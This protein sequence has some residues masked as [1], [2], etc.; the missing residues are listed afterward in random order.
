MSNVFWHVGVAYSFQR[1]STCG[2]ASTIRIGTSN[3]HGQTFQVRYD[4]SGFFGA[5]EGA[6]VFSQDD[7]YCVLPHYGKGN[8]LYSKIGVSKAPFWMWKWKKLH[9][10]MEHPNAIRT[11]SGAM[12]VVAGLP[13]ETG[14]MQSTLCEIDPVRL[15][16][17]RIETIP[18]GKSCFVGLAMHDDQVFL[19]YRTDTDNGSTVHLA[20]VLLED[21]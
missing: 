6:L 19:S 14:K 16:L 7:G 10:A 11:K 9:M 12:L 15:K 2:N 3:D 18:S 8:N 13:D 1:G 21:Q 5:G 20:R 17:V 4:D